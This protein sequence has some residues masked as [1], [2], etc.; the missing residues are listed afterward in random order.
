MTRPSDFSQDIA[1]T[2]CGRLASGE[3]LVRICKSEEMPHVSTVYRWIAANEAFRDMYA[4]ARE[5][6]A[7][8]LADEIVAIADDGSN[9]TYEKDGVEFT[10]Q[11]VV[12]RSKLRVDA[13]KW[14]AAKLKP[15]KYGDKVDH[16]H[17][18]NLTV[19]LQSADADL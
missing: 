4:R 17:G 8:T 14:V 2:I 15:K 5:D 11:D 13:R 6:Q 3:P 10:N 18:G 12:A 1:V 19:R 16:E 9:D 7:D